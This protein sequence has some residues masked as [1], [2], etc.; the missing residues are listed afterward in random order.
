MRVS[1]P[2]ISHHAHL[3][4]VTFQM[5]DPLGFVS[6]SWGLR[7]IECCRTQSTFTRPPGIGH[8]SIIPIF[9]GFRS[10]PEFS[11]AD[12]PRRHPRVLPRP[13]RP[14]PKG[15]V[16]ESMTPAMQF[17]LA[18][19][20]PISPLGDHNDNQAPATET[21]IPRTAQAGTAPVAPRHPRRCV[22]ASEVNHDVASASWRQRHQGH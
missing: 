13:F 9:V 5:G 14:P 18:I 8:D 11:R 7:E 1:F 19:P 10:H 15:H 3:A 16:G 2:L 4:H 22:F 17:V 21:H 12:R 6:K 20:W